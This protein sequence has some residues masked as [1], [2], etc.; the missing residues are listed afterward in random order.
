M[1]AIN[2]T[3]NLIDQSKL[4]DKSVFSQ[5]SQITRTPSMNPNDA[6]MTAQLQR[7]ELQIKKL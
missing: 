2:S 5:I 6:K 7:K 1:Q 3:N 4:Q